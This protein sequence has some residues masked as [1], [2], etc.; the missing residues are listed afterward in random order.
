MS[1][2]L[3]CYLDDTK[4]STNSHQHVTLSHVSSQSP[5]S[6]SSTPSLSLLLLVRHRRHLLRNSLLNQRLLR[7]LIQ[8]NS[9]L[10]TLHHY[11]FESKAKFLHMLILCITML[12]FV[13]SHFLCPRRT[14]MNMFL[15][16]HTVVPA[17]I[18]CLGTHFPIW[19][20]GF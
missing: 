7:S 1:H 16:S 9:T 12:L 5:S 19:A 6:L 18:S 10:R 15:S 11:L 3:D 14:W 4:C 17:T 8:R 2:I 20:I 13:V